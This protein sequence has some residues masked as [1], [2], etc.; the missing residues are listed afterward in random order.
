MAPALRENIARDHL[1]SV[2]PKYLNRT[3]DL[4]ELNFVLIAAELWKKLDP[5]YEERPDTL[6]RI[7]YSHLL[8][9]RWHIA[10]GLSYFQMSDKQTS[11]KSQIYGELNY[12][13]A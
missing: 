12:W 11:E 4:F 2:K 8:E 10:E 9:E 13:Q 6:T 7:A 5:E 1:L 3:L